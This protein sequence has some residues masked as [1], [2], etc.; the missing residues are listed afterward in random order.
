MSSRLASV[1]NAQDLLKL[2]SSLLHA[3]VK[4]ATDCLVGPRLVVE[5]HFAFL[6]GISV[7][8]EHVL[9]VARLGDEPFV[10]ESLR[11]FGE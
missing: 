8:V 10:D 2:G 1:S 11:V 5:L 3:I 7:Q 4:V 9:E 6:L